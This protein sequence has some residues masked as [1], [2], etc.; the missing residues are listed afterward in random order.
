MLLSESTW[1]IK[2]IGREDNPFKF[3]G[4]LGTNVSC[5][6]ILIKKIKDMFFCWGTRVLTWGPVHTKH[7]FYM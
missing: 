3:F 2:V 7:A 1:K 5:Q 4:N 6:S